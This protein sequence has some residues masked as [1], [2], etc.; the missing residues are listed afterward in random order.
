MH[1]SNLEKLAVSRPPQATK[2]GAGTPQK[3]DIES[4]IHD[5]L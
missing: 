2:L 1:T 3:M 5:S 4:A